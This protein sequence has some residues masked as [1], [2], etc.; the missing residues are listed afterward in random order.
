MP[1]S[2]DSSGG[3]NNGEIMLFGARIKIGKSLSM[4]NLSDHLNNPEAAKEGCGYA[5][6]DDAAPKPFARAKLKR[7]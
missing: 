4:S 6:A 5:S 3:S 1:P 7:G 2:A